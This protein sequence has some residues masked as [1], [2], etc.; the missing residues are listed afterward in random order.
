MQCTL[1]PSKVGILATLLTVSALLSLSSVQSKFLFERLSF[2]HHKA[3]ENPVPLSDSNVF[4][5][6]DTPVLQQVLTGNTSTTNTTANLTA[7]VYNM[8]WLNA[9]ISN[10]TSTVINNTN[11]RL[12]TSIRLD[13]DLYQ[14]LDVLFAEVL[15]INA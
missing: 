5:Q 8:T 9:Q 3:A 13:K 1:N 10:A 15:L 11:P 7:L 14:P 6:K 4:V 12:Q 2:K